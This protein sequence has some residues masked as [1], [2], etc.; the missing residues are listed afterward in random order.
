M[1][2]LDRLRIQVRVFGRDGAGTSVYVGAFTVWLPQIPEVGWTLNASLLEE[3]D[4]VEPMNEAFKTIV[5]QKKVAQGDA[6][7]VKRVGLALDAEG[8][9][10]GVRV[11][12]LIEPVDP[13]TTNAL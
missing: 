8:S 13:T 9:C 7:V 2:K 12:A 10:D 4:W 3:V 11:D 5:K 6:L 1:A